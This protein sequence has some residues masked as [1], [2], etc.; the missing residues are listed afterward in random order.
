MSKSKLLPKTWKIILAALPRLT[1]IT[2][3]ESTAKFY[4]LVQYLTVKRNDGVYDT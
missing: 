1:F 2:L 4:R 3:C